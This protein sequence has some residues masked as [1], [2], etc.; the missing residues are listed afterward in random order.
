MENK[1][2]FVGQIRGRDTPNRV[3]EIT[4]NRKEADKQGFEIERGEFVRVTI[5]RLNVE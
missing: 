1:L 2:T 5:E 4:I 3:R